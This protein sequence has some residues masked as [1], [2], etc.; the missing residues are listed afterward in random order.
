MKNFLLKTLLLT[1]LAF[2]FFS[3]ESDDD[4][5]WVK[6]KMSEGVYILHLGKDGNNDSK[7]SYYD[8]EGNKL[9][10]DVFDNI[11]SK[12]LG[13]LGEDMIIYGSKMYITVLNSNIIYVT[14][15]ESKILNTI[16]PKNDANQPLSPY[17]LVS[18]N[19]KVYAS[20]YGGFVVQI[21]TTSMEITKQMSVGT[22]PEKMVVMNNKLYVSNTRTPSDSISVINLSS[23]TRENNIKVAVNPSQMVSDDNGTLYVGAMGDYVDNPAEL[24]KIDTKNN[25]AVTTLSNDMVS[26]MTFDSNANRVLFLAYNSSYAIELGYYDIATNKVENKSFVS[27]N[28]DNASNITIDPVSGYFYIA[29]SDY[30][31]E[32]AVNVYTSEGTFVK[33]FKTGG[34]N[35]VK[36]SFIKGNN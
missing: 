9:T 18:H 17:G 33:T 34:L 30:V 13:D 31:S 16:Q 11:N 5:P 6:P 36:L 27:E 12:P 7:L 25:N 35:P 1:T 2:T 20:L 10:A 22:Y 15:L 14:D 4:E 26:Q 23:F 21:D 32:G 3:C 8:I 29:T 28:I 19:G 24:Q